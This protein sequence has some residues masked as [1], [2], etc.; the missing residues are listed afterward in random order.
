MGLT[1]GNY[2]YFILKKSF[3]ATSIAVFIADYIAV[4]LNQRQLRIK[5]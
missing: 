4:G 3:I 1:K 2:G 5:N